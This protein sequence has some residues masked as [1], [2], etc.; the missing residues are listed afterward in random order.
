MTRSG[1]AD[2]TSL[3]AGA[4]SGRVLKLDGPLSF[5]GGVDETGQIVDRHHPQFGVSLRARVLAMTSGRGSSSSAS[6]LAELLRSGNGPAAIVM[7]E[8]DPIVTLG[9]IVAG[10]LYARPTP[11][12]VVAVTDFETLP[13]RAHTS[14]EAADQAAT[15]RWA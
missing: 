5:W 12:V 4:A 3:H 2:G 6:V 8:P 11:V 14:V 15:V 9:A 10:E 1:E 13:D 7:T